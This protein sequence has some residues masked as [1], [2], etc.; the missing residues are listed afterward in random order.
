MTKADLVN[1]IVERTGLSK[2]DVT[3]V[4]NGV[5]DGLKGAFLRKERVEL[6]GFGIFLTKN[7]RPRVGRN[8]KTREEVKIPGRQVL[9]FK[10]SRAIKED[11]H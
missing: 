3:A 10:P 2:K 9:V 5:F 1:R 11:L 7:R 4:V 6:R 8:P